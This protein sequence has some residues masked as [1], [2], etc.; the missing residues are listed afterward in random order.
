MKYITLSDLANTIRNNIYKIPHDIDFVIGVPRSGMICAS[1]ISE[2]INVPLIDINGFINGQELDGGRRLSKI[3]RKNS[4]KVLVVDD[5]VFSGASI[6]KAKDKLNEFNDK[7]KFI[8]CAVYLEGYNSLAVDFWLEDLRKYTHRF[9]QL[10]MYEWN[11]FHHNLDVMS[12]FI[13]DIDGVFCIDPCDER[14]TEAYEKYIA[15]AIPLFTPTVKVGKIMTYRLIKYKSI[16]QEW[17]AKN[18]IQYDKLIMFNALSWDERNNSGISSS[19]FKGDFYKNDDAKLFIESDN[20][21]AR[22]IYEI[23]KKPVLCVSTN[24]LYGGE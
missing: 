6:K 13:F 16:T 17:L 8:Y 7:Y 19:Q 24:I 2:F 9:T 10:V 11:I 5:T 14:N 4:G 20:E 3:D 23:S 12:T 15:N 18:N 1:I 22:K 21:Q